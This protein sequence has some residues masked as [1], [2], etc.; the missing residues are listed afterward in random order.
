MEHT[1]S[2]VGGAIPPTTWGIE[3]PHDTLCTLI[4][5]ACTLQWLSLA[6]SR[7]LWQHGSVFTGSPSLPNP[8]TIQSCGVLKGLYH[9]DRENARC[10]YDSMEKKRKATMVRLSEDDL[11]A[12]LVI[13]MQTGI[14]SDNQAIVY[15]LHRT[16]KCLEGEQARAKSTNA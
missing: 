16:A 5:F 11:R 9:I 10:Y 13:R 4:G 8:S 2:P 3:I 15:A 14:T 6:S 1:H 7:G 12:I